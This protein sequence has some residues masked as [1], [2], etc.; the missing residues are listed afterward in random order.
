MDK[1]AAK[2]YTQTIKI[3]KNIWIGNSQNLYPNK[4]YPYPGLSYPYPRKGIAHNVNQTRV[5]LVYSYQQPTLA[6]F[7]TRWW[8]LRWQPTK[9]AAR[10]TEK[11]TTKTIGNYRRTR[12]RPPWPST[13]TYMTEKPPGQAKT[14]WVQ[15]L[16]RTHQKQKGHQEISRTPKTTK[17]SGGWSETTTDQPRKTKTEAKHWDLLSLV[18][19][20]IC[21][22]KP[23]SQ[24]RQPPVA[25]TRQEDE[26]NQQW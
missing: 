1:G 2:T 19:S 22:F 20:Q 4:F 5:F 12:K 6:G 17:I 16:P 14:Q 24:W 18:A 9:L 3:I 25:E 8:P 23:D 10:T 21:F 11:K 15:D 7:K 26:N 13:S